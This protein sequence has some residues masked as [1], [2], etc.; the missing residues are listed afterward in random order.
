MKIKHL[1]RNQVFILLTLFCNSAFAEIYLG[2]SVTPVFISSENGSLSP[3]NASLNAGFSYGNH[4]IELTYSAALKTDT[5]N[6]LE[7]EI[8]AIT[9][10]FY[11]YD[12]R[13]D[14]R[15]NAFFY[16]GASESEILSKY[17]GQPDVDE[18]YSGFSYGFGLEETFLSMPEMKMVF[19]YRK[20]Y[21]GD[22]LDISSLSLGIRYEF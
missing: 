7:I 12:T 13:P 22:A 5:L 9:S 15:F 17:P 18:T 2:F 3:T 21:S 11:R 4:G 6:Q 14:R 20:L 16:L 1:I 8:P 10:A 19:D